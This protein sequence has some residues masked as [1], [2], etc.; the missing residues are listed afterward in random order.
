MTSRRI[1]RINDQL[2]AEISD[3]ISREMK[4]PRLHGMISVT[5]VETT[6]DLRRA[7]VYI[8]ILGTDEE[9]AETLAALQHAA[10]FFRHELR[11]RLHMKR[12]PELD[13]RP[14]TSMERADRI[15]RLLRQV[16]TPAQPSTGERSAASD[17]PGLQTGVDQ[18]GDVR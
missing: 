3:L 17:R 2:R 9:R 1:E 8:S 6:P 14:D 16:Q 18:S 11:E 4:D 13:L 12:T 10:G 5:E 15:M 7:K